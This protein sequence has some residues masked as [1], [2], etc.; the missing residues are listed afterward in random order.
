MYYT[1]VHTDYSFL[2]VD[3][4]GLSP[5]KLNA[6]WEHGNKAVLKVLQFRKVPSIGYRC[7]CAV[8]HL[9]VQC[10]FQLEWI[11]VV[12]CHNVNGT[13]IHTHTPPSEPISF[14]HSKHII[15]IRQG[16]RQ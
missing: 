5:H 13:N 14:H 9:V 16:Y 12:L 15:F 7:H 11:Q 6:E 3:A 8:S 1:D 10:L 2:Y 4:L